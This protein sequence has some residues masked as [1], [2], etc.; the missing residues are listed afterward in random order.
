MAARLRV[1]T[2]ARH[3]PLGGRQHGD[4]L[5][6]TTE[7]HLREQVQGRHALHPEVDV[8]VV[9]RAGKPA[10]VLLEA[11]MDTDLMLI[12]R[13]PTHLRANALGTLSRALIRE[14]VCAVEVVPTRARVLAPAPATPHPPAGADA[15]G[16][17]Y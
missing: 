10:L 1:L 12:S 14:A 16:P 13:P 3:L 9:V 15:W 6:G 7:L 4:D 2:V 17:I 8:E 11:S 5:L